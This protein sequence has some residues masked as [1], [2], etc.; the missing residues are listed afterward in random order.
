M[1]VCYHDGWHKITNV[2]FIQHS[3]FHVNSWHFVF[4]NFAKKYLCIYKPKKEKSL[5]WLLWLLLTVCC[6]VMYKDM[7]AI[8]C[9]VDRLRISKFLYMSYTCVS[10]LFCLPYCVKS[11][12]ILKQD[13]WVSW[14]K[15]TDPVWSHILRT[16]RLKQ[17]SHRFRYLYI[18]IRHFPH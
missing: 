11:I 18:S 16:V 1:E 12:K 3:S 4:L 10:Q 13:V 5:L 2:Q 15:H 14:Y 6:W 8:P 17:G 9:I 7:I